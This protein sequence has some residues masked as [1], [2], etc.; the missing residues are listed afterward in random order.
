MVSELLGR[1]FSGH[2]PSRFYFVILFYS[3]ALLSA[4]SLYLLLLF[5]YPLLCLRLTTEEAY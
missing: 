1:S 5:L 3:A 2:L 4:K